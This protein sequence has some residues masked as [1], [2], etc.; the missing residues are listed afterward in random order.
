MSYME[1]GPMWYCLDV[2]DHLV[3]KKLWKCFYVD[4]IVFLKGSDAR[5]ASSKNL[6]P[7]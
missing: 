6:L 5:L 3:E 1:I 7:Q 4:K 2:G